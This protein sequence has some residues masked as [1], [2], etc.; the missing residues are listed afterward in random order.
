[1]AVCPKNQWRLFISIHRK[2]IISCLNS[3]NKVI[4]CW[5][6]AVIIKY[7]IHKV[8]LSM[9]VLHEASVKMTSCSGNSTLRMLSVLW[10]FHGLVA[11]NINWLVEMFSYAM[12]GMVCSY[13]GRFCWNCGWKSFFLFPFVKGMQKATC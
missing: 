3:G 12:R 6:V 1:M 2:I 10:H 13:P 11:V 9:N 8:K 5:N 7:I 4:L